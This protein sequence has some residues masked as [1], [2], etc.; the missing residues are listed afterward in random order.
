MPRTKKVDAIAVM[1]VAG[2]FSVHVFQEPE[3]VAV[4]LDVAGAERSGLCIGTGK[5]SETAK[6][7][8]KTSLRAALSAIEKSEIGV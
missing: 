1:K 4:W 5:T 7:D 3:H 2:G 6:L 8:A